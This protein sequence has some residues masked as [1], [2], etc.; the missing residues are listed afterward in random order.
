MVNGAS[1][2]GVC[3]DEIDLSARAFD[4]LLRLGEL[5]LLGAGGCEQDRDLTGA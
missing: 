1:G 4:G 3:A 2:A 5:H